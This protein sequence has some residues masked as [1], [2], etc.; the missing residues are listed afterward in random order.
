MQQQEQHK[1]EHRSLKQVMLG[2]A[3]PGRPWVSL[4]A[5]LVT[6]AVVLLMME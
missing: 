3:A 2:P 4:L 1:Q 6:L 5:A